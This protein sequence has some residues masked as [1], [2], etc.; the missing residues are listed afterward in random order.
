[1][2]LIASRPPPG[3]VRERSCQVL[4]YRKLLDQK[5]VQAVIIAR[6]LTTG[7]TKCSSM[8]SRRGKDVYLEKPATHFSKKSPEEIEAVEQSGRMVQNR[9]QQRS[10]PH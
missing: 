10:R 1:M 9:Y 5:E 2:N 8:R 7:T 3:P 4:D 6:P